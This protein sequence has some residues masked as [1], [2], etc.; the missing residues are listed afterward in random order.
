MNDV[1][2]AA[3]VFAGQRAQ[4]IAWECE[5]HRRQIERRETHASQPRRLAVEVFG[6]VVRL[7]SRRTRRV[8]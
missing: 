8:A 6:S 2:H 3:G 7:S 1:I 4:T 5:A